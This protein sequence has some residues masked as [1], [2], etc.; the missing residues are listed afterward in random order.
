[1]SND[2]KDF[3]VSSS[4]LIDFKW[5]GTTHGLTLLNDFLFRCDLKVCFLFDNNFFFLLIGPNKT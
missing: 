4:S 2:I 3:S 1:M 5:S